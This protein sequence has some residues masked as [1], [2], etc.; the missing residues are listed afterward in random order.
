LALEYNHASG[1]LKSNPLINGG[2]ATDI[3]K[4]S[5]EDFAALWY[6]I[7]PAAFALGLRRHGNGQHQLIAGYHRVQHGQRGKP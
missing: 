1:D 5:P 3:I 7:N 6:K 4:D 2:A